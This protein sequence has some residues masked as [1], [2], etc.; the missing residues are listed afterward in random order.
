MQNP[1]CPFALYGWLCSHPPVVPFLC[2]LGKDSLTIPTMCW[3][4]LP[5][6]PSSA[7][8]RGHEEFTLPSLSSPP[9]P[10]SLWSQL[11]LSVIN[12]KWFHL[13]LSL[14]CGSPTLPSSRPPSLGCWG[15][16]SALK[17]WLAWSDRK[18]FP[19]QPLL[20]WASVDPVAF[21]G[22]SASPLN[23]TFIQLI[24]EDVGR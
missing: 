18:R 22:T 19:P 21:E 20:K 15:F 23:C 7:H 2:P 24:C 11:L 1:P 12:L 10:T 16:S 13:L 17:G 4:E 9:P 8:L 5:K 6:Q 3:A 14:L